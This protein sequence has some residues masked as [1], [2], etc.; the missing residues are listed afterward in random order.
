MLIRLMQRTIRH[1]ALERAGSDLECSSR[2]QRELLRVVGGPTQGRFC[3]K[4]GL[5]LTEGWGMCSRRGSSRNEGPPAEISPAA[6]L[7]RTKR[8]SGVT[9]CV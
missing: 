5:K 9:G 1:R 4:D 2:N 3:G 8:T 6:Q 7:R